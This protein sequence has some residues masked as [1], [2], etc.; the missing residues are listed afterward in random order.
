MRPHVLVFFLFVVTNSLAQK[1]ADYKIDE[2]VSVMM[3]RD[4]EESDTLG[5]KI[6]KGF[7][8][9]AT[10]MTS[11]SILKDTLVTLEDEEDLLHY[12]SGIQKGVLSSIRGKL[13]KKEIVKIK[14]LKLMKLSCIMRLNGKQ[15]LWESWSLFLNNTTYNLVFIY[16]SKSDANF[17]LEKDKIRSSLHFSNGLTIENQYNHYEE[18]TSAYRM[19]ELIGHIL[20]YAMLLCLVLFILFKSR[21]SF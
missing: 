18:S 1:L 8:D 20:F 9:D 11:K 21:K 13:L 16:S 15:K 6:A 12:Y 3:P 7:I 19:G 10:I 4:V 2:Y 17:L 14:G 5:L